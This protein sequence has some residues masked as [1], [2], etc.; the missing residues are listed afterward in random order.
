MKP[1]DPDNLD[2]WFNSEAKQIESESFRNIL[3]QVV[4]NLDE[5]VKWPS[6]AVL[7]WEGCVKQ[8]YHEYPTSLRERSR[9]MGIPLDGRSNGPAIVAFMLAGGKRPARCGRSWSWSI[10]HIYSGL[11]PHIDGA[12]TTHAVRDGK[13][14]TQS[15]GLIAAHPI[16]DA[17]C[18]EFEC[19]SWYIRAKSYKL[20][21]YDPD[22]VFSRKQN[23]VGFEDGNDCER[24]CRT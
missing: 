20:F 17:L 12:I 1:I 2:E 19:F 22:R 13:H 10:H 11:F 5:F 14:F 16:A 9:K 4:G 21:K 8:N 18:D 15:A 7:L 23:E 6:R 3:Q 24:C